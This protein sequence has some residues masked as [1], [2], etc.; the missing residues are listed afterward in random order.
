MAIYSPLFAPARDTDD[1]LW[2]IAAGRRSCLENDRPMLHPDF[3]YVV[4]RNPH[5]PPYD[6]TYD[7][8]S[9]AITAL[10]PQGT[11]AES[12]A[13]RLGMAPT[14]KVAKNEGVCH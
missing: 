9:I 8:K 7:K 11:L 13:A 5:R 10:L 2:F 3:L 4:G 1:R 14:G 12:L 6:S